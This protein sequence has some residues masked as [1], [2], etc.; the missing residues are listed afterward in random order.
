MVDTAFGLTVPNCLLFQITHPSNHPLYLI[1]GTIL[2]PS[3]MSFIE[4]FIILRPFSGGSVIRGSLYDL[5]DVI[6]MVF[7]SHVAD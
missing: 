7:N 1:V 3:V 6:I 5:I 4:R 2:R